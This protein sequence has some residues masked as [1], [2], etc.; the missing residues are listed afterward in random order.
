MD[1][2]IGEDR[3]S[4]AE[5]SSSQVI[6]TTVG[7]RKYFLGTGMPKTLRPFVSASVG[8]YVGLDTEIRDGIVADTAVATAGSLFGAG[9]DF[10]FSRFFVLGAQAG[11]HVMAD[12]SRPVGGKLNYNGFT[13]GLGLH[14]LFGRGTMPPH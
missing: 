10:Q 4:G 14:W 8:P 7:A 12:F 13:L 3:I 9:M 6:A 2:L 11:Y 1:V 5:L